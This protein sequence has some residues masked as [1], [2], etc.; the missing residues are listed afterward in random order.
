MC[1]IFFA[2]DS[3]PNY[4]LILAANRDEFY[5]R[6]TAPADYWQDHPGIIGGRDLEAQKPDGSCGTWMGITT[7]GRIGMITNYRDPKNIDPKAP[8]RGHL[9][10]DFLESTTDPQQY[11]SEVEKKSKPYN[12]FN[13]VVG[14]LNQLWYVSNYKSGIHQLSPGLHGLSNHLLDTPWPKVKNGQE[15]FRKL[16]DSRTL[17]Y[18][19]LFQFLYNEERASDDQLPDTGIGLER[20]RALSSMFIKTP[21]Y[22]SR[23]STVMLADHQGHVLFAERTYDLTTFEFVDRAFEFQIL[24]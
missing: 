6:Q 16:I 3:H 9:V 4:K 17:E 23:C 20:E 21:N 1:L 7:S 24:N 18:E 12:G 8:S 19:K 15:Q 2:L 5:K 11:A 22:G 14:D 10:S 13:L